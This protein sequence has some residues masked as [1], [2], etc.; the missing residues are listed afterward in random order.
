M[1]VGYNERHFLPQCLKSISFCDEI[2]Y[3]DLGST[4]D[5]LKIAESFHAITDIHPK[6]PS[7]E[8]VQT[9]VVHELKND[10][11]IFIDPDERIDETLA[12]E[13]KVNFQAWQIDETLGAVMAPWIFYF[14]KKPLKGTV[15]GGVN[16]KYLLVNRKR[17]AF[18]PVVHYGRHILP[19]FK[20]KTIPFDKKTKVLHHYWMSSY[21]IFFKKHFRYLK[22]EAT[23]RYKLG[24][25]QSLKTLPIVPFREFKKSFITKKGFRDGFIGFFLSVFWSFYE[26]YIAIGLVRLQKKRM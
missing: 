21:R 4:D 9:K 14:K 6:V 26:T 22:N 8:M 18:D 16:Y 11:V 20:T 25:R 13:I 15:W 3:T 1:V 24:S 10:W 7:C 19:G 2:F 12:A 23:D 17:F 5:S